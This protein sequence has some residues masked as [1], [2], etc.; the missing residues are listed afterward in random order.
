MQ[1]K[2]NMKEVQILEV[3]SLVY[4]NEME[5]YVFKP[6][7]LK[8]KIKNLFLTEFN[9]DDDDEL[10]E[11]LSELFEDGETSDDTTHYLLYKKDII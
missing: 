5:L 4:T 3:T 9:Y 7:N 8:K 10:A 2:K 11:K 6:T 1:K